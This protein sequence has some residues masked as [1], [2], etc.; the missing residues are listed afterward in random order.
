MREAKAQNRALHLAL[1]PHTT[2]L[3]KA[4]HWVAGID[5][6]MVLDDGIHLRFGCIHASLST[7]R[8]SI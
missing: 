8:K 6:E 4:D 7:E 1:P 2:H 5:V 3:G